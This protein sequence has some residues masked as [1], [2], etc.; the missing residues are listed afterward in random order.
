MQTHVNKRNL[1]VTI[2]Q[3]LRA[4]IK[5]QHLSMNITVMVN[6][7]TTTNGP[8]RYFLYVQL[9]TMSSGK[10]SISPVQK[11]VIERLIVNILICGIMRRHRKRTIMARIFS[12]H[13]GIPIG[14]RT[15]FVK[16]LF[17]IIQRLLVENYN[18]L[19]SETRS[20]LL[21]FPLLQ[22]QH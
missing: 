10:Q 22:T 7:E 19:A 15:E 16:I 4:K 9:L 12:R 21:S 5:A 11:S 1:F 3:Y 20:K 13:M 8:A 6:R 17:A 18:I 14:I 2:S